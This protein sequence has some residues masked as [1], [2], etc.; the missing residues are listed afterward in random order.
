MDLERVEKFIL[1]LHEESSKTE[2]KQMQISDKAMVILNAIYEYGGLDQLSAETKEHTLNVEDVF[3]KLAAAK[4]VKFPFEWSS[5]EELVKAGLSKE[6]KMASSTEKLAVLNMEILNKLYP[7]L[8]LRQKFRDLNA[9]K[10]AA[11]A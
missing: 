4:N 1:W 2:D 8:S 7:H 11:N 6:V 10:R 5:F 3:Q 9:S